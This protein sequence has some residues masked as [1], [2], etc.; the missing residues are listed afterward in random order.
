MILSEENKDIMI[1]MLGVGKD[2]NQILSILDQI[3]SN[4]TTSTESAYLTEDEV[5]SL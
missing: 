2:G 3:T 1:G 4:I 5:D